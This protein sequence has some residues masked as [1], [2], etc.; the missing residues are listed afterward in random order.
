M[1][2]ELDIELQEINCPYQECK[3]HLEG[4][5][6]QIIWW[7]KKKGRFKCKVCGRT[8]TRKTKTFFDQKK[9]SPATI[10]EV[11]L[12]LAEGMSVRG[13]ARVKGLKPETI[14]RWRREAAQHLEELEHFMVH[15][16]E[17][18]QVQIDEVWTFLK[19]ENA[20]A[21]NKKITRSS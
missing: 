3:S 5:K 9:H 16:L 6:R 19:K 7:Q 14:I 4:V 20:T 11:L 18:K 21:A 13:L 17:L 8:F 15:E 1:F 10:V 2:D 12:L